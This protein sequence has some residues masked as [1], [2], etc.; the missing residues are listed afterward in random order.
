MCRCSFLKSMLL[1]FAGW[2]FILAGL[3]AFNLAVVDRWMSLD[4]LAENPEW[5]IFRMKIFFSA[6]GAFLIHKKK[7]NN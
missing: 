3:S 5:F 7:I 4:P 6:S 1:T 2:V